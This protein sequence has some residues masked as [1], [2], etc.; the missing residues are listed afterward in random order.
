M[1]DLRVI[2]TEVKKKKKCIDSLKDNKSP[3]S[4]GLTCE[5]Y[6]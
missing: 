1:C 6:G 2:L 5:F 4:D 3:G